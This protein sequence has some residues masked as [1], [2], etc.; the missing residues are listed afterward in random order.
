MRVGKIASE[1]EQS[2]SHV[3]WGNHHCENFWGWFTL[4]AASTLLNS[5]GIAGIYHARVWGTQVCA[6][7]KF[8]VCACLIGS[9][10][11]AQEDRTPGTLIDQK[12][13]YIL[14]LLETNIYKQQQLTKKAARGLLL[15]RNMDFLWSCWKPY[16]P[17]HH[18]R[19]EVL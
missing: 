17:H 11:N 16:H 12:G 9:F 8:G 14:C 13:F 19:L 15:T 10:L 3:G 4:C 6:E 5:S 18:G 7:A 2:I 1:V